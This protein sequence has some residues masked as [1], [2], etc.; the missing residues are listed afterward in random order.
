VLTYQ[1]SLNTWRCWVI[2]YW[3]FDQWGWHRQRCC[4]SLSN[5]GNC[6]SVIW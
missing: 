1:C 6:G 5:I 2:L 4:W 3:M